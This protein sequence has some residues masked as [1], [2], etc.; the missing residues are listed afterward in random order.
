MKGLF[1]VLSTLFFVLAACSIE[2][3][4]LETFSPV[5][6]PK[7]QTNNSSE[8]NEAYVRDIS[9]MSDEQFTKQAIEY[10]KSWQSFSTIY[11]RSALEHPELEEFIS[12]YELTYVNENVQI[13]KSYFDNYFGGRYEAAGNATEGYYLKNELDDSTWQSANIE[14]MKP[15]FIDSVADLLQA[16]I[17]EHDFFKLKDNG[18]E[19]Y[20]A[21]VY[22][23]AGTFDK[24]SALVS[25]E[26]DERIR[27]AVTD[28]ILNPFDLDS[29]PRLYPI[30]NVALDL[31]LNDIIISG[32]QLLLDFDIGMEETGHLIINETFEEMDELTSIPL[33]TEIF[34]K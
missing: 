33:P 21:H 14:V 7:E 17:D 28:E 27:F 3:D 24:I 12:N 16:I 19:E 15:L 31:Y 18:H 30:I 8:T 9:S 20:V 13:L 11:E 23:T 26:F 4:H 32:Y 2:K 25:K 34:K 29:E 6:T 10:M 1:F 5:E 22:K